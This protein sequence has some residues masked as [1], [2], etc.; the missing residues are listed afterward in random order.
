MSWTGTEQIQLRLGKD[1]GES[2]LQWKQVNPFPAFGLRPQQKQV[3]QLDLETSVESCPLRAPR[4]ILSGTSS[5]LTVPA[6]GHTFFQLFLSVEQKSCLWKVSSTF[7][8]LYPRL[9]QLSDLSREVSLC[10]GRGYQ[11]DQTSQGA[12][13]ATVLSSSTLSPRSSGTITEV[14]SA[15]GLSELEL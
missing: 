4:A 14:G 1:S 2:A 10:R 3:I 12:H 11:R 9:V 7:V 15:E 5:F 8:S 6:K 13:R